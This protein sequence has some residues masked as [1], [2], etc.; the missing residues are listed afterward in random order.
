MWLTSVAF[1]VLVGSAR[2]ADDPSP[3][4]LHASG[5]RSRVIEHSGSS[6]LDLTTAF[7]VGEADDP[8]GAEGLAHFVE[9][10]WFEARV[11][12]VTV[13]ER[14][15]QLG[16][17]SNAATSGEWMSFSLSCPPA[18]LH[19]VLSLEADRLEP[20]DLDPA[21]LRRE[22]G[23]V[24]VEHRERVESSVDRERTLLTRQLLPASHPVRLRAT[25]P[26]LG[27]LPTLEQ[28]RSFVASKL[29]PEAA[30][31]AI[32]GPVVTARARDA[33]GELYGAAKPTPELP[34]MR[35]VAAATQALRLAPRTV[36]GVASRPVVYVAWSRPRP[37]G[38]VS[39]AVETY[40]ELALLARFG[41]DPR[42]RDIDC[43]G[44]P[45]LGAWSFQCAL[46]ARDDAA[47][48]AL[49][50]ELPGLLAS[51][52]VSTDGSEK[53]RDIAAAQGTLWSMALWERRGTEQGTLSMV[54]ALNLLGDLEPVGRPP[55][56]ARYL[57]DDP[58]DRNALILVLTG[59]GLPI[60]PPPLPAVDLPLA[61]LRLGPN[62]P[63]EAP[64]AASVYVR[65]DGLR[66]AAVYRPDLV[67]HHVLVEADAE[68]S[69]EGW[70][71][72]LGARPAAG[73]DRSG[74]FIDL[75]RGDPPGVERTVATTAI[76]LDPALGFLVSM[77]G[78]FPFDAARADSGAAQLADELRRSLRRGA[79]LVGWLP[80]AALSPGRVIPSFDGPSSE[81]RVLARAMAPYTPR[82]TSVAL[83]SP[84]PV[85][86]SLALLQERFADW[87][88]EARAAPE[89][90]RRPALPRALRVE[91]PGVQAWIGASCPVGRGD[92]RAQ[93]WAAVVGQRLVREL[94]L[95]RGI[96]YS[97]A[98]WMDDTELGLR[99]SVPP[100]EASRGWEV[101][102][103]ALGPPSEDELAA[104]RIEA[105]TLRSP[106][107]WDP[108]AVSRALLDGSVTPEALGRWAEDAAATDVA[109]LDELSRTCRAGLTRVLAGPPETAWPDDAVAMPV[110]AVEAWAYGR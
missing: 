45:V 39:A 72:A 30:A 66:L 58:L 18:A 87:H 46:A 92:A 68:W 84:V 78:R 93:M 91:V 42:V 16:C 3:V 31:V 22:W 26:E 54:V 50:G 37:P 60:A 21:V 13:G 64:V 104:A 74:V 20:W 48:A 57:K 79:E 106:G 102:G 12:G 62:P 40:V 36:R 53:V 14:Y 109:A 47:A 35:P 56:L 101:V 24:T 107:R 94:R 88:P 5:A 108:D 9:H 52:S 80:G 61:P 73:L 44:L 85:A 90:P 38:D 34:P 100:A 103:A 43:G 2:A 55:D 29:R 67:L 89:L 11:S 98:A 86:L 49:G 19:D 6:S 4:Q 41:S 110:E 76:G 77:L 27:S 99:F 96:A 70:Q 63:A 25:R 23:V 15:R 69:P 71:A 17:A 51:T 59:D 95:R 75:D 105:R 65:E 8:V 32:V 7:A 97:P 81:A 1:C 10:L 83:A 33:L 28:V 82:R